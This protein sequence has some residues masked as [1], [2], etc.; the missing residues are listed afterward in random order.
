MLDCLFA[1]W[2]VW[3][4]YMAWAKHREAEAAAAKLP[5]DG[6]DSREGADSLFEVMLCFCCCV[7]VVV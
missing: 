5:S 3:Q 4:G 1:S 6:E 2:T 7:I